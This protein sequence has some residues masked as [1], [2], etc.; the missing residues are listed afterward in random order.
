M[1][2]DSFGCVTGDDEVLTSFCGY[3]KLPQ[4]YG[5]EQYEF[6]ILYL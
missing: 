4:M 5:L 1:S 3:N 6:L 2:E